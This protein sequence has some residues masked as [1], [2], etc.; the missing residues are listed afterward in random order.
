MYSKKANRWCSLK[1]RKNREGD[2]GSPLSKFGREEQLFICKVN[3]IYH[4]LKSFSKKC[5]FKTS[6]NTF[7]HVVAMGIRTAGIRMAI[8]TAGIRMAIRTAGIRMA[9][10]TAVIYKLLHG[11][12]FHLQ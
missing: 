5:Q 3:S 11:M 10:R 4:F 2:R 7:F 6:P 1:Q 9:I 8:R 12:V